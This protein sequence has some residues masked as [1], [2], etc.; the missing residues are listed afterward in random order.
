M[1]VGETGKMVLIRGDC[2][3]SVN[4]DDVANIAEE[5]PVDHI[6]FFKK[7]KIVGRLQRIIFEALR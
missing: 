3:N 6:Y 5:V 2:D 4:E 1:A 7:T